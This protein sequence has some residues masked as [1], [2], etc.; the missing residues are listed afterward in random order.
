M[1]YPSDKPDSHLSDRGTESDIAE[2]EGPRVT[3][4]SDKLESDIAERG[5]RE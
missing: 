1:T 2:R 5:E 4:P 3:Y